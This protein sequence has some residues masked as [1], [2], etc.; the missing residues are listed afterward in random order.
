MFQLQV[1]VDKIV[2]VNYH[3]WGIICFWTLRVVMILSLKG[4]RWRCI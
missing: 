3:I 4:T 2:R 1:H